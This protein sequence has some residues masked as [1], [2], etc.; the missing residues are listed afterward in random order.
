M[1]N[2]KY[3]NTTDNFEESY[4]LT[5]T[6]RLLEENLEGNI[7]KAFDLFKERAKEAST[8][9]E[10]EGWEI[11]LNKDSTLN[12]LDSD[13]IYT[14]E[15]DGKIRKANFPTY[16]FSTTESREEFEEKITK[17]EQVD[18]VIPYFKY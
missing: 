14:F 11:H 18:R 10:R 7:D 2:F 12:L 15:F 6:D 4:D 5:I 13:A 16:R 3:I 9:R 17:L 8:I 1:I